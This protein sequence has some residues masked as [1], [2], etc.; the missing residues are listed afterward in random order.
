MKTK[1]TILIVALVA[2]AGFLYFYFSGSRVYH[3]SGSLKTSSQPDIAPDEKRMQIP[4]PNSEFGVSTNLPNDP[5]LNCQQRDQLTAQD[6]L[7]KDT[8][9]T[10]WAQQYPTGQGNLQEKNFL[11]SGSFV[12]I[13]T[14][15][16][17][18]RNASHDLRSEPP[19][20]Q[21]LVSP[22]LNTTITPDVSRRYLEIGSS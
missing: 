11:Q 19:N 15:G 22:W 14:V 18:L 5:T 9:S 3:N 10:L 8:T 13:N 2:V 4:S 7:P 12:G 1:Q 21:V 6:L 17:S 16:S 20:P